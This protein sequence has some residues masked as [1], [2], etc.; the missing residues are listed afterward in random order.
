M[1][2]DVQSAS[3]CY[4]VNMLRLLLKM[5]LI[6]QEEYERIVAISAEHYKAE[7]IYCV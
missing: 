6:S 2:K 1:K 5:Q 3:F 4:E 7:K